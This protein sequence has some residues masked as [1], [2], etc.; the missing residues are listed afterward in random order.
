MNKADV[1]IFDKR[2]CYLRMRREAGVGM[3]KRDVGT[4]GQGTGARR[5]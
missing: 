4:G 2:K 3:G 1:C 5:R